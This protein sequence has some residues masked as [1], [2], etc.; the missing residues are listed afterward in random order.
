MMK[1]ATGRRVVESMPSFPSCVTSAMARQGESGPVSRAAAT[2][3]VKARRSP[4]K[5][6]DVWLLMLGITLAVTVLS[7]AA[8]LAA[9]PADMIVFNA[10]V[11]T[12]AK[13]D[14][15][16]ISA[17]VIKNGKVA[18]V[19]DNSLLSGR[20]GPFTKVIDAED[21]RMVPGMT[22]SHTHI[23]NGGFQLDRI[24]LRKADNKDEFIAM[25][26]VAAASKKKGEWV[27]GGRWSVESWENPRS[28][29]KSWLD[30][31]TG[32]TPVVL[33]RM[34]G[35]QVLVNSA[36][37]A[38]AGID[39]NGPPDPK[40]GEIERD[41]QT[42]EPTG[43][44]KESA[45]DLVRKLVPAP[46]FA[47]R[48]AAFRRAMRHA[49]SFGVTAVHDM[50]D[51][52]DLPVFHKAHETKQLT[53]RITSYPQYEDWHKR[54]ADVKAFPIDDDW[55]SV[56]GVKVYMDG[57]MG[58]RTAYMAEPYCD[59]SDQMLHPRGQLT[60]DAALRDF[61]E[62]VAALHE[63]GVQ[64][65]VHAIGD[66]ANHLLLDAY[67][68]ARKQHPRVTTRHRIEHAQHLLVDDF[69]RFSALGVIASM[70]PL[71]KADDG[72]YAEGV[73]G[74]ERL[75]GSYAFRQLLDANAL[76]VFGSDWP[77]VSLDP[78]LG[79]DAAVS[80]RTL[81]GEVWLPEHSLKINEALHAYTSSP[82]RAIGR[83]EN[84]GTLE[85]GKWGDFVLLNHDPLKIAP[86]RLDEVSVFLTVVA[87]EIVF[88]PRM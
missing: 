26:G 12:G 74:K 8:T 7:P 22:D 43:V 13:D 70:Q 9:D 54:A 48:F 63:K 21:R 76:L 10:K 20:I 68:Y 17:I 28:P 6:Y 1:V 82:P 88:G 75:K 42:R 39:R 49:N 34:D 80:A 32:D 85:V 78:M 64:F 41:P 47:D 84:L 67:A 40:G 51:P 86:E 58:S 55:L 15:G 77:V 25:V 18:A 73:I 53:V 62:R 36:A 5:S 27:T 14:S 59:A 35:H 56:P 33:S 16:N 45:A 79:L 71:H 2:C 29:N 3:Q 23:I 30:P 46:S 52:D 50:S 87:G 24:D 69:K 83:G 61:P 31:V 57:S 60:A 72:R 11:W 81:S 4:L 65:A 44:L 37:L 38:L 19:G 66:Q